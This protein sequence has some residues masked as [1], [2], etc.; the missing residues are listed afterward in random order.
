MA[1]D[2]LEHDGVDVRDDA[3]DRRGAR[4]SRRSS[5]RCPAR[6][7]GSAGRAPGA[8]LL[9]FEDDAAGTAGLAQATL[10]VSPRVDR[11]DLGG[12][13]GACAA[14]RAQRGVEGLMLKRLTSAYGVGRKRGDWWK[15][16]I[17][18]HTIDAVLIYAQ[19]G[20]GKRASLLTD[21][22]FG[23]WDDG[24][25]VPVAKA[26]SGLTNE[27]IARDGSLD[28]PPH[29]RALR[30]GAARRAGARLRAGLRGHRAVDAPPIRASPC[31]SR[32]CC[33]GAR[34]SRR[35]EADTLATL[36]ALMRTASGR[37]R[38][39]LSSAPRRR[40]GC[41][42]RPTSVQAFAVRRR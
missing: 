33:A 22:T 30:P 16:K 17:D 11:R 6:A 26:Y 9:P 29:G 18:P 35:S 12:A 7:A 42:S 21:Y 13:R 36:E 25:L 28:P 8:P 4:G 2:V 10:R 40:Y 1:Y 14:S 41:R 24:E 32:A 15:W 38:S 23:L 37:R 3:A 27:E 19:P 31:A 34:T 39:R 5:P 20:S